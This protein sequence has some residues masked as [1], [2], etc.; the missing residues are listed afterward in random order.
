MAVLYLPQ[1]SA[2]HAKI[3]LTQEGDYSRINVESVKDGERCYDR[4][5]RRRPQS[6]GL[7]MRMHMFLQDRA[8]QDLTCSR[9]VEIILLYI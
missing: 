7:L 5:L 6:A 4:V 2:A 3:P 1:S 8:Q 9:I